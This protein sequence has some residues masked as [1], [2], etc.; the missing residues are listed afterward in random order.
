[1][2][3]TV[4]SGLCHSI[5][6]MRRSLPLVYYYPSH[7]DSNGYNGNSCA[8]L[9][10]MI[11]NAPQTL[12]QPAP[13]TTNADTTMSRSSLRNKCVTGFRYDLVSLQDHSLNKPGLR[14]KNWLSLVRLFSKAEAF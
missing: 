8:P 4:L 13:I 5:I 12:A 9:V 6:I 11:A 7:L 3:Y 1:M 14:L 2:D 10:Y